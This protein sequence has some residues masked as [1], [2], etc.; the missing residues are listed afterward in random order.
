MATY[1]DAHEWEWA[2]ANDDP[3]FLERITVN[4]IR[5]KLTRY[6]HE[7]ERLAGK[8]G[9]RRAVRVIRR[10]VYEAIAQAYPQYAAECRRQWRRRTEEQM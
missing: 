6:D 10:R 5:H 2:S 7:L 1:N 9:V 8:V 4:F 3:A